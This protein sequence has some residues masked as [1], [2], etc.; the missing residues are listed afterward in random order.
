MWPRIKSFAVLLCVTLALLFTTSAA[1]AQD[2]NGVTPDPDRGLVFQALP[3]SDSAALRLGYVN[4]QGEVG[5]QYTRH[6]PGGAGKVETWGL[7]ARHVW[8]NSVSIPLG[9]ALPVPSGW[10]PDSVEAIPYLGVFGDTDEDLET[11]SVGAVAGLQFGSLLVEYQ[12]VWADG[13]LKAALEQDSVIR[14]GLQIN[15]H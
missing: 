9:G 13:D 10:L 4:S 7:W 12:Y 15:L 8:E 14:L 3:N 1:V 6:E 2:A 11:F 5:I